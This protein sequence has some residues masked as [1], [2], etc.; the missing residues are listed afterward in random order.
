VKYRTSQEAI[1]AINACAGENGYILWVDD[2]LRKNVSI[3]DTVRGGGY[4]HICLYYH[5]NGRG[6]Y[7]L[8]QARRDGTAGAL[9]LRTE[10]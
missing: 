4:T 10:G 3:P 6:H 9:L 5:K 8:H 7:A 2:W 1:D